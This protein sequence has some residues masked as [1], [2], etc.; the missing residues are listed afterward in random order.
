MNDCFDPF[1]LKAYRS[2]QHYLLD[3]PFSVQYSA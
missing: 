1:I 2:H 3:Q